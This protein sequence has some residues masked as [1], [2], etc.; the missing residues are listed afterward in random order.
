LKLLKKR[1][2]K[3]KNVVEAK[4][5]AESNTPSFSPRGYERKTKYFLPERD[6]KLAQHATRLGGIAKR[7][8]ESA[9]DPS[10]GGGLGREKPNGVVE[11]E[12]K[13]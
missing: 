10:S 5:L 8:K 7:A 9:E 3:Q 11:V 13:G 2:K 1:K 12:K 6:I 4:R